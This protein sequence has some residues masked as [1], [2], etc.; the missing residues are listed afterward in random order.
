ME[1]SLNIHLGDLRKAKSQRWRDANP[2]PNSSTN[3]HDNWP[4][5]NR[6]L[7]SRKFITTEAN[8]PI[9]RP[10]FRTKTYWRPSAVMVSKHNNE[11][12]W[13]GCEIFTWTSLVNTQKSEPESPGNMATNVINFKVGFT[14]IKSRQ[15]VHQNGRLQQINVQHAKT[16]YHIIYPLQFNAD[17]AN[18]TVSQH[19]PLSRGSGLR[20]CSLFL[21][22]IRIRQ[23]QQSPRAFG[24]W[25]FIWITGSRG[26]AGG[27]LERKEVS[28]K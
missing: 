3:D 11:P 17:C 13:N 21:T 28:L 9:K 4:W 10:A 18:V 27:I 16:H 1:P 25:G 24:A 22:W 5:L 19:S 7:R 14:K 6:R 12:F 15:Q 23:R 2:K 26:L 20:D 8:S